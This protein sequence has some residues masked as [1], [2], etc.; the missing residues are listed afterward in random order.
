MSA[1]L[2]PAELAFAED[3]T[4]RSPHYDD[5]Y[6][7]RQGALAQA[8]HVF[9]AGNMLC[10]RWTALTSSSFVI[11]ENGFGLGSNFLATLETWRQAPRSGR[12]HYLATELHPLRREDMQRWLTTLTPD[13]PKL[14]Q[15][16]R[17]LADQ[18]PLPLAGT[19]RL[20][21]ADDI[22]LTLLFGDSAR[23]LPTV[24]AG[25]GFDAVYLDGF[26]PERNSAMWSEEVLRAISRLCRPNAT[27][28]TWCVAGA[29]R[30]A[31]QAEHWT[32][33]R[34]PGFAGKREM[35][36]ASF[37]P[38]WRTKRR[39]NTAFSPAHEP[40]PTDSRPATGRAAPAIA[41]L[42]APTWGNSGAIVIGAGLAGCLTSARLAARGIQVTLID[43]A[44]SPGC[45]ASGIPAALL[46][47]RL[48]LDDALAARLARLAY[49]YALRII[50]PLMGERWHGGGIAH[51]ASDADDARYQRDCLS[52]H[53]LPPEYAQWLPT[54]ALA[55]K[56]G[57]SI[58]AQ[59][60]GGW[61]FPNGGWLTPSE[62]CTTLLERA[63][64]HVVTRFDTDV[65][66]IEHF[67]G[68]WHALDA[69]GGVRASAETLVIATAQKAHSLLPEACHRFLPLDAVRGQVTEVSVAAAPWLS[70]LRAPVCGSGHVTP[71]HAGSAYVGA[72]FARDTPSRDCTAEEHGEN[73]ARL[74]RLLPASGP[75]IATLP[76]SGWVG[77]RA[78]TPDRL[79]YSGAVP[80]TGV[81]TGKDPRFAHLPRQPGLYILSGL[82]ARGL[83][84][85]PLLA[86]LLAC[87]VT[88]ESGP[89]PQ[90]LA[91]ALDP[92]RYWL[93][94]LRHQSA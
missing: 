41:V 33:S 2:S 79:P 19:H 11:F 12:L 27:L 78:M 80:D 52:R 39:R 72:S 34:R 37:D 50:P 3:G 64:A 22:A 91:D 67:D 59:A 25:A 57:M 29:V 6:H 28:A 36:C 69:A 46:R 81:G 74:A 60:E 26:A 5:V 20:E 31:L 93:R 87:R 1:T 8:R 48:A 54:V 10:E 62:L 83:L 30:R 66:R 44:P 70:A 43:R 88:G 17:T 40:P 90:R 61:W 7:A 49:G 94:W 32:L 15:P 55:E 51:L 65:V 38:P 9:V 13:L 85:A 14:A 56:V 89:L 73:L 76:Y 23:I 24:D 42:P 84:W 77:A 47:P 18:W 53:A 75:S 92:A 21:I 4:P 58:N 82:G 86:E 71:L 16:L 63:G 45:G 68:H 35:L